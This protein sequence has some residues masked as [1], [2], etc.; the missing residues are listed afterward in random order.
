VLVDA[1]GER[2]LFWTGGSL[3]ALAGALDLTL[4]GRHDFR[5]RGTIGAPAGQ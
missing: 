4:L 5:R 3:L 2:A 1:V